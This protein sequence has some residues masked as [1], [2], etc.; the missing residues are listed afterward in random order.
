MICPICCKNRADERIRKTA[1]GKVY[2][3]S[4]CSDCL[5]VAQELRDEGFFYYYK[6]RVQKTC[7]FCGRTFEDFL[8]T[9]FVGC[10]HCYDTFSKELTPYID[11]VQ[12]RS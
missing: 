3:I 11:A 6:S 5:P 2:E 12:R 8:R 9:T 7:P 1:G 4:V 10:K